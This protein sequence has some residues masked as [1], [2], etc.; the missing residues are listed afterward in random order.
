MM[1][2]LAILL[3]LS[4]WSVAQCT[5]GSV[6]D[7]G[8]CPNP[9]ASI[10]VG[11]A[12]PS[13][14]VGGSATLFATFVLQ[15]GS[16]SNLATSQCSWSTADPTIATIPIG[17]PVVVGV[18][19]GTVA[20]TC[21]AGTGVQQVS[22]SVTVNVAGAPLITNPVVCGSPPCALPGG[23]N[24]VAYS[25]TFAATG[26]TP[27]YSWVVS[28][29][30][31]AACLSGASLSTS[32]VLTGTGITGTC[33]ATVQVTDSV[34][35]TT[36]LVV[37]LAIT[38]S[39]TCGT[40]P[41]LC[42]RT[43]NAVVSGVLV[44]SGNPPSGLIGL[45][46]STGCVIDDM[47]SGPAAAYNCRVTNYALVGSS[48]P[49]STFLF[50]VPS[51][52]TTRAWNS[53]TSIFAAG[54]SGG[55]VDFFSYAA[56]SPPTT[57]FISRTLQDKNGLKIQQPEFDTTSQLKFYAIDGT[58][59]G[60]VAT[61]NSYVQDGTTGAGSWGSTHI[62]GTVLLSPTSCPGLTAF[63]T[64]AL[65]STWNKYIAATGSD[66]NSATGAT[67]AVGGDYRYQ[68]DQGS[69]IVVYDPA[70][71][72]APHCAWVDLKTGKY[73]SFSGTCGSTTGYGPIPAPAATVTIAP[74]SGSLP[75]T[76]SYAYQLTYTVVGSSVYG[77]ESLSSAVQKF[78]PGG[79]GSTC[80][81]NPA[82]PIA[83]PG[84][85]TGI[86]L[87]ETATGYNLYAC[88]NTTVPGCTPT[89]QTNGNNTSGVLAQPVITSVTGCTAG[90][91]SYTY[92]LVARNS[93]GAS[94]PSAPVT[95]NSV[96]SS[97]SNSC[98][99]NFSSVASATSYDLLMDSTSMRVATGTGTGTCSPGPLCLKTTS[100]LYQYVVQTTPITKIAVVTSL[101]TTSPAVP[102]VSTAGTQIHNFRIDQTGHFAMITTATAF[103]APY[104]APAKVPFGF[105]W[106]STNPSVLIPVSGAAQSA[107]YVGYGIA[108][109]TFGTGT[110]FTWGD[111]TTKME[112]V[113]TTLSDSAAA[114][115][116]SQVFLCNGTIFT[117]YVPGSPCNLDTQSGDMHL[118]GNATAVNE[119]SKSPY[120]I[121]NPYSLPTVPQ[122]DEI[123]VWDLT[124][125]NLHRGCHMWDSGASGFNSTPRANIS[126]DGTVAIYASDMQ[127]N[128]NGAQGTATVGVGSTAGGNTCT[129]GSSGNC[130]YDIYLCQLK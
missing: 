109:W 106:D 20:I 122:N 24:G 60:A 62:T 49:A 126:Q 70:Q 2:H 83:Q 51:S 39:A 25:F 59:S 6:T 107:P 50:T 108:H 58:G 125:G 4:G 30:S 103:G 48:L 40:P 123:D 14:A 119:V 71:G 55:G 76:H 45:N 47:N 81:F 85:G 53:S 118:S 65:G 99:V 68:Q 27:P 29:G 121:T 78:T 19:P 15:N 91:T 86:N 7:I 130:R 96:T 52:A 101:T 17:S 98:T 22:G 1:K 28:S 41:N 75:C 84:G 35:N 42:A 12:S 104:N 112:L 128:G 89:L 32:G 34:S 36:S 63:Q 113:Q 102:S 23:T 46:G 77:G 61:L 72:S 93:G 13:I 56:G 57:A 124:N 31:F 80:G 88:D 26:G 74:Q 43:D 79:V 95:V 114:M 3:L 66:G 9:V 90:S 5:Q 69:L 94:P 73:C 38:G 127:I 120:S 10:Q 117:V 54:D 92:W 87:T 82:P 67:P 33:T 16:L 18:A 97:F 110:M 11:P 37:S 44:N 129:L 64:G 111:P 105:L 21:T 100:S 116:A 8:T 115:N